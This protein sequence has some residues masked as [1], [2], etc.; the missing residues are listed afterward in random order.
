[1]ARWAADRW[2]LVATLVVSSAW[3]IYFGVRTSNVHHGLGTSAYDFGLYEQGVWLLSRFELPFVTLM[4][5]NLFGDHSS[6]VL[7]L[8][9][10]LYWFVESTSV[11]F[12]VQAAV[13]AGAAIPIHLVAKRLTDSPWFGFVFAVAYL[14]HPA[15]AWTVL[16]NFHPD[17]FLGLFVGLVLWAAIERRWGWMWVSV[18]LALSVKEDAAIALVPIGMWLM[19]RR[20]GRG[21]WRRGLVLMIVSLATMLTM[22]FVVMRSFTGVSFRNSWR[23]PFGG[24]SGFVRTLVSSPKEVVA[25]FTSEGRPFYVLQMLAPLGVVF[26]RAPALTLTASLVLFVNVLSTFWYQFQIEYHY[27]LVAVP[28]IVVG[29]AWAVGRIRA[30]WRKWAVVSV[31]MFSIGGAVLWS[32]SPFGRNDVATWPPRHPVAIAAKEILR[33]VPADASVSAQHNVS[34]HLARREEVYM[35]P[36][37]FRRTLYGLDV[38]AG[39][40]RLAHAETVEYVVLQRGLSAQDEEVWATERDEFVLVGQN[41]WWAVY[42]RR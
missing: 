28:A 9:V 3:G 35:F 38:F 34:A 14:L 23:I 42:R 25:H 27:S 32:P 22:L 29:S 21:E 5:R 24:P 8:V 20:D 6:F 37:P 17:S 18:A 31:A 15:T 10:P 4:G 1:M 12:F 33:L 11:L 30:N 13:M 36:N 2:W 39:G 26:L 7:L 16:E 40:D 41:E 19:L